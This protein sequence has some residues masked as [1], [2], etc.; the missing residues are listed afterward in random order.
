MTIEEVVVLVIHGNYMKAQQCKKIRAK[1]Q[2]DQGIL[3]AGL[4]YKIP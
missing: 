4:R 2:K 1:A 3:V